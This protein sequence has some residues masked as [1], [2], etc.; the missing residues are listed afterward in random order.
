MYPHMNN[1]NVDIEGFENEMKAQR[2]RARASGRFD[3]DRVKIRLYE[4]LGVG[5]TKFL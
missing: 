2:D 3:D 4:N 5:G 1:I